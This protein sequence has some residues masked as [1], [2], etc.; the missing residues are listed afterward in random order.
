MKKLLNRFRPAKERKVTTAELNDR[1]HNVMYDAYDLSD[2]Q[3]AKAEKLEEQARQLE[4][5]ADAYTADGEAA[6]RLARGIQDNL[7]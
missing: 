5:K 1:L 3:A 7:L 6:Y 4:L 2:Q